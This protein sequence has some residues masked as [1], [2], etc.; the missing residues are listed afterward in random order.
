MIQLELIE[1]MNKNFPLLK[2][3]LSYCI[4]IIKNKLI[5]H[6]AAGGRIEIRD[7][8][9]FEPRYHPSRLTCNPKTGEQFIRNPKYAIH[10]KQGK[11]MKK[12]VNASRH[13]PIQKLKGKEK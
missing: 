5:N 12:R 4:R 10:F 1:K 13:L 9:V 11:A 7:F 6:L 8:G 3:N 2:G